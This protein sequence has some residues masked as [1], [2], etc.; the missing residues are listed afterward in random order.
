MSKPERKYKQWLQPQKTFSGSLDKARL[1]PHYMVMQ[2]LRDAKLHSDVIG[3]TPK[4][5]RQTRI[6]HADYILLM[7]LIMRINPDKSYSAF[8]SIRTL[9][10]ETGLSLAQIDGSKKRLRDLNLL[11][12]RRGYK[13]NI[14]YVNVQLLQEMSEKRN[15]REKRERRES[16]EEDYD[17]ESG[18]YLY[19]GS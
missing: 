10:A 6:T 15:E 8:P 12:W 13:S 1:P 4:K 7:T 3:H 19:A 14:Y 11:D 9:T 18:D 5:R 17:V 16:E 2:Y